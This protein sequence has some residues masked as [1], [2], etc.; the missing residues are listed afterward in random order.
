M[1][2]IRIINYALDDSPLRGG[3]IILRGVVSADTLQFLKT[4]EY[5]RE[6]LAITPRSKI[7]QGLRAGEPFPDI[8]L[9]MR[10]ERFVERND[11][12]FLQDEVYIIDGL[13]RVSGALHYLANQTGAPVRLGAVVHFNT[14]KAWERDRFEILNMERRKVSP[15]LLLRNTADSSDAIALLL[16][17]CREDTRFALHQRVGWQQ[18]MKRGELITALQLIKTVNLLHRH[19][20]GQRGGRTTM[21][22]LA[23]FFN[24]VYKEFG[25]QTV[26]LNTRAYFDLIDECWGLRAIQYR[27]TAPQVRGNFNFV[28]ALIL[29]DHEDFWQGKKLFVSTDMKKKLSKFKLSDPNIS[30][31]AS[32][33]YGGQQL[34]YAMLKDHINSGRRTGHIKLRA[35]A[36]VIT[37][38][39]E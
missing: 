9:G 27:E 20:V 30:N 6:I 23:E 24:K 35:N 26:R 12:I 1:T 34:L 16:E 25:T 5:Q 19:G 32:S 14:T 37:P 13:Q 15:N 3:T 29:S 28:L 39:D 31:L 2:S 33:G 36:D 10:G 11:A 18:L 22:E 21:R 8:E 17:M 4:D 7:Q 38:E